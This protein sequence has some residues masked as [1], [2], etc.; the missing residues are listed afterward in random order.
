MSIDVDESDRIDDSGEPDETR[1]DVFLSYNSSDRPVVRNVARRLRESRLRVWFDEESLHTGRRLAGRAVGPPA[2]LAR[3]RRLRRRSTR[4]RGWAD[5]EMKVALDR[6]R[7]DRDFRSS[8]CC[9]PGSVQS[10]TPSRLPPFLA[11][12]QWVDL[13]E[14]PESAGAIQDLVNA[15]YGVAPQRPR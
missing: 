11:T 2:G 13:R 15:I 10:S 9:S 5:L 8:R 3:L 7:H 12:R 14:G 6:A 1:Y 4:S